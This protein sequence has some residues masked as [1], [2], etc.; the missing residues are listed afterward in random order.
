MSGSA[1]AAVD[2]DGL[3][4]GNPAST[5]GDLNANTGD[6]G[7]N[8]SEAIFEG[9]LGGSVGGD[10]AGANGFGFAAAM[11]GATAVVGLETVTYSVVGNVLTAKITT[12]SDASRLNTNLFTVE[13]TNTA[14]GAYKVTLLDNVLHAGGPNDEGTDATAAISYTITDADG[15][16]APT[17]ALTITFDDDAPT[18]TA[19]ALQSVAE[20]VTVAG[21]FDF[22]A[23]ADG[24][25]LTAINGTAVTF[26]GGGW[27]NWC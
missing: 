10:G 26:G 4:G 14:T 18:A 7:P 17:N 12:T 8:T 5:T 27:S 11:N 21:T 6:A 2:D 1:A 15:S 25:S 3:T 22:V 23:G 13:I 19:E 20:G 9:T 24:G 16:V